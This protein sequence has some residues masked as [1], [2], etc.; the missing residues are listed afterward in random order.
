MD[1]QKPSQQKETEQYAQEFEKMA[2][3][4]SLTRR[5][6]HQPIKL[7]RIVKK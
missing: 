2:S 3:D 7:L 1:I 4:W 6:S 5:R